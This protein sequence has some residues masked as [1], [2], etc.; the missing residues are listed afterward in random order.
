MKIAFLGLG[1][2]GQGM[3][4]LLIKAGHDLNVFDLYPEQAKSLVEAGASLSAS[5]ADAVIDRDVVITMLP[6]DGALNGLVTS[7]NGL[8]ESMQKDMIHMVMGT[9]GIQVIRKLTSLHA[10]ENQVFIAAHVLGRPD[11]AATGQLTIVPAG[12]SD[13]VSKMQPIFDVLGKQTFV[14]GTDPQSASAVKIANNFVLGCAIEVMG[15]AMSLVRKLGVEPEMFHKVLTDGLF[16]APA[17]EVYGKMIVDEAYD[18]IGATAVIGLKD[19]N[20][21]LEAS[22][23]AQ[24]PLPS[25]SIFRDRLIGAISR[26]EG[27][28]DWAVAA[29]EQARASGIEVK[30]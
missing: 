12:P 29:K 28:L 2:M 24:A 25:A 13:S 30:D 3:A 22:E 6:S 23:A 26:G 7:P 16:G 27:G 19:M 10:D 20:L 18:S 1:R 15:E 21:A 11:L 17:Y 5:V 9:H 14:A 4:H 8:L